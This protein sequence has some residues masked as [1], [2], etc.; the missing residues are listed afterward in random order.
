MRDK[1]EDSLDR[2]LR[3]WNEQNAPTVAELERLRERIGKS[4]GEASFLEV[5]SEP[6]QHS[7]QALRAGLWFILGAAAAVVLMLSLRMGGSSPTPT[8]GGE[9]AQSA[10]SV[11]QL[12]ESQLKEKAQLLAGMEET[13]NGQLAWVAEHA[14][15]VELGLLPDA[16]RQSRDARPLALRLVVVA[17][18]GAD[19]AWRPIWQADAIAR[20]E[21]IVDLPAASGRDGSLRLWM[22]VLPDGAIAVDADLALGG[23][24]PLRS[25]FS[26][27]QRGGVP[28]RV[29]S[30]QNNETEYQVYQTVALLAAR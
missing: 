13:F 1:S 12:P 3:Q 28:Q 5:R 4:V 20:D 7:S 6:A 2:L 15:H 27:L 30:L 11:A 23:A 18:Q 9:Q 10:P 22:H 21:E 8:V 26:G 17:R 16:T 25:T 14:G 29:F 19:S 24:V